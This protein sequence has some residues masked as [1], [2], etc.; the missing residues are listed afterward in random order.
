MNKNLNFLGSE[1]KETSPDDALFHVIPAAMEK[2]VSYGTGTSMGPAA[3]I[4]ASQQLE[5]YDGYS[6]PSDEGIYTHPFIDCRGSAEETV[7][8]ISSAVSSAVNSGK[9]PVT[10]GG[11]HT[12]TYGCVQGLKSVYDD[13]GVIQYDAHADLRDT[14]EGSGYSHA[15]V[16][17]RIF[18]M[19]VPFCQIGIRSISPAE[20]NF[21]N[22]NRIIHHD[23]KDLYAKNDFNIILPADF[24]RNIY[25]TVDV[26]GLD[27]SVI[28]GTGTPEPGGLFWYDFFKTVESVSAGRKIIGFDVVEFAPIE[29]F[30]TAEFTG[31]RL[32]YNM[33]GI[34]QRNRRAV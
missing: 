16:M 17:R 19:N 22:E 3:L 5:V 34:V 14:Y 13:F 33:M 20:V 31:A 30:H 11:E 2:S 24:P 28:P 12:V 29:N 8:I 25:I 32:I 21:R 18:E 27:P 4:A 23:A 7:K 15:C 9:I 10:L 26:D 6:C 1:I